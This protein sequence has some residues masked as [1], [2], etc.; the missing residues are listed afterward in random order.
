MDAVIHNAG[1]YTEQNRG[2][3]PEGHAGV[4][5]VNTRAPY[6]L[7]ALIERPGRLVY[8]SSGLHRGGEGALHDLDWKKRPWIQRGPTPKASCTS[9]RS[10]L[11]WHDAGRA[12]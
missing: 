9:L 5:A 8:I 1:V 11:R 10:R 3:T 7:T 6:I 4:L 2:L 12:S